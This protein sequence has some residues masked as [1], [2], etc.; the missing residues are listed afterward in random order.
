MATPP[1]LTERLILLPLT[2]EDARQMQQIFPRW[3]IVRHLAATVPWPFP[4]NGAEHYVNQVALPAVAAGTAWF[5]SI[6]RTAA[7]A[8]MIGLIC[9][10]DDADNN[11]GFWLV[12]EWQRQ[13]LMTEACRIVT[14]FWFNQLQRPVLRAPK[15]GV[16]NGSRKISIKSGMRLVSRGQ[17]EYVAGVLDSEVWEIT[18]D[19]WLAQLSQE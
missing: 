6:R 12:P 7:P 11:R 16:N 9:L 8:E 4:D 15:A 18:R 13:G 19:E 5:W 14:D 17:K 1:L 10:S 3:E 2:A